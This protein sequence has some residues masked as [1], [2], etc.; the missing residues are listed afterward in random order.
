[1]AA[2]AKPP[3]THVAPSTM[4]RLFIAW[5]TLMLATISYMDGLGLVIGTWIF[6]R[7]LEEVSFLQLQDSQQAISS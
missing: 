7:T 1:M 3:I 4:P 6:A 5:K 2:M